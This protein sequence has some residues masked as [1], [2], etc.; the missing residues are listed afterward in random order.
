VCHISSTTHKHFPPWRN[1]LEV[2]K[3]LCVCLVERV[4]MCVVFLLPHTNTFHL[5]EIR[6]LGVSKGESVL[7]V[8]LSVCLCLC[9]GVGVFV[10]FVG[11]CVVFVGVCCYDYRAC[12]KINSR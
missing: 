12:Q 4:C 2:R 6:L 10:V 5:D 1:Q 3:C 7:C 11:V 9:V 8:I